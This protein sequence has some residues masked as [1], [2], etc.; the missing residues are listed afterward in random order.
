MATATELAKVP[1]S[2]SNVSLNATALA[3]IADAAH[4]EVVEGTV[5]SRQLAKLILAV[6]ANKSTGGGTTTINFRDRADSKNRVV[7]TVD[8]DGNRTAV[9][10]DVT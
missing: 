8:A 3:A 1:K 4:D 2:D 6:L 9:T 7:A 5:T 10:L